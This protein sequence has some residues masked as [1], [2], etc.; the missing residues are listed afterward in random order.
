MTYGEVMELKKLISLLEEKSKRDLKKYQD[1][2]HKEYLDDL[3]GA[4]MDYGVTMVPS[5]VVLPHLKEFESKDGYDEGFSDGVILALQVLNSS[6]DGGGVN[7]KEILESADD[8]KV[9]RRAIEQKT[10]ALSGL[11]KYLE[12]RKK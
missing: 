9:L 10:I 8:D 2:D 4:E 5:S 1:E 12:E 3:I 11:D 6:G 7:Y